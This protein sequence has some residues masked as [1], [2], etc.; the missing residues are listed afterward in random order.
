MSGIVL[1]NMV[2]EHVAEGYD[3]LLEH[4]PDFCGCPM[5]RADVMV[6]ALNRLP[7]RYV[8]STEGHVVTE[9]N[10]DKDQMRATIEVTMMD[11]FKKVASAPRCG[12]VKPQML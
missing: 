11:G 10:L 6:F 12:R 8:A 5:C 7:A 9:L 3:N 4:F 2:E 1:R